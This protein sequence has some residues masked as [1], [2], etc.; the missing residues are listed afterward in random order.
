MYICSIDASKHQCNTMQYN[1]ILYTIVPFIQHRAS[2]WS[3]IDINQQHP[4]FS[5][6]L[7]FKYSLMVFSLYTHLTRW[8]YRRW[9]SISVYSF[10]VYLCIHLAT[11]LAASLPDAWERFVGVRAEGSKHRW[12]IED[13]DELW[14]PLRWLLN[15]NENKLHKLYSRIHFVPFHST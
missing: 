1:A 2:T 4:I 9:P 5:I 13:P 12:Y 7:L 3:N 8:P 15:S 10:N 11:I 6:Y 14:S